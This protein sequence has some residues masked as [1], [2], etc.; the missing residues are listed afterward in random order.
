MIDPHQ[1][2]ATAYDQAWLMIV[3]ADEHNDK[4]KDQQAMADGWWWFTNDYL[5]DNWYT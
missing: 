1:A 3:R 5:R 2:S 4:N